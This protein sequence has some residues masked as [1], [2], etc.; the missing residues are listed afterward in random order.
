[1]KQK[2]PFILTLMIVF[3]ISSCSTKGE[4]ENPQTSSEVN[5]LIQVKRDAV[6]D[7][8]KEISN[9]EVLQEQL[10][11]SKSLG[12]VVTIDTLRKSRF[13]HQFTVQGVATSLTNVL[14]ASEVSA[15]IE[16]IYVHAGQKVSKGQ[17]LIQLNASIIN[18]NIDEVK[19]SIRLA[20]TAFD[21][22]ERLW[23]QGIGSE[24]QYLQV[25]SQLETFNNRLATLYAQSALY[26]VKAPVSG[27]VD[28]IKPN[29][30]EMALAGSPLLRV[31]NLDQMEIDAEIPESYIGS[32]KQ[33]DTCRITF[34]SLPEFNSIG[35]VVAV[36]Q[37]I[38][39]NNRTF[40]ITVLIANKDHQIKPNL[41]AS[42]HIYDY[43]NDDA[44]V[45]PSK[46]ILHDRKDNPYLFTIGQGKEGPVAEKKIIQ[47]G[48]DYNGEVEILGGISKGEV[49][50][51]DGYQEISDGTSVDIK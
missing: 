10:D 32:V 30:G 36:G 14:V 11:S 7:L 8:E 19:T 20:Q 51:R 38:N 33:N 13:V 26:R 35:K 4:E 37:V 34:A 27:T 9:L 23:N 25:K 3:A 49:F 15:A 5:N 28:E 50:I 6:R 12:K 16:R 40:K 17:I 18:R 1:M 22:Q 48:M 24:M 44:I 2:M 46:L 45:V 31:L 39:A 43:V 47:V 29:E 42:I 41:L 21:K